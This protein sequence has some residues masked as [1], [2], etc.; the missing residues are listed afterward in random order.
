M[1]IMYVYFMYVLM[2]TIHYKFNEKQ[3]IQNTHITN[4]LESSSLLV[5]SLATQC[6]CSIKAGRQSNGWSS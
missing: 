6:R 4:E 3:T 1:C 5:L 2:C